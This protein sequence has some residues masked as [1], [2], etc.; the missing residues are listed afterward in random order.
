VITA[1]NLKPFQLDEGFNDN[2]LIRTCH[3]ENKCELRPWPE[4]RRGQEDPDWFPT[5]LSADAPVIAKDFTIATDQENRRALPPDRM[6]GFI[7]PRPARR[8][9]RP[10]KSDHAIAILAAFKEKFPSWCEIDWSNLYVEVR[11]NDVSVTH[12]SDCVE[13]IGPRIKYDQDNFTQRMNDAIAAAREQ[14]TELV[15]RDA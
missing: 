11:D 5:I 4:E 6:S 2:K 7:I 8:G 9:V 10:F 12:I 3:L 15:P 14:T 13:T 1:L